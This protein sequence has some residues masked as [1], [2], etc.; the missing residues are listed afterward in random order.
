MPSQ[1]LIIK[2]T[3]LLLL[4]KGYDRFSISDLQKS[5]GISRG[6]LYRYFED[7]QDLAR[8]ACMHYFVDRFKMPKELVENGSMLQAMEH[9]ARV[10]EAI[11]AEVRE[12]L[13]VFNYRKYNMLYA[14]LVLRDAAFG[15]RASK[16]FSK[17]YP[18]LEN[19]AKRGE[20]RKGL[21]LMFVRN[22]FWDILCRS[23]YCDSSI[24]E[25]DFVKKVFSDIKDFYA[26]IKG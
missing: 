13:G 17:M 1:E 23:T 18:I 22:M 9:T 24:S 12:D 8:Q 16:T 14:E 11:M 3:F 26:L 25:D 7:K 5:A 4:E 10:M 20:I 6:L 15:R 19:A 21:D 2:K